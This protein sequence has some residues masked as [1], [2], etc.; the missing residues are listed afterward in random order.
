MSLD[1][2]LSDALTVACKTGHYTLTL[3]GGLFVGFSVQNGCVLQL[4]LS[5]NGTP[6]SQTEWETLLKYF[7]WPVTVK[8]QFIG[9]NL[10]ASFAIH[11]KYI[12]TP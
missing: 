4:T 6:P 5:R 1:T 2:L 11:P 10:T 8:P 9:G 7:P 12:L 3:R